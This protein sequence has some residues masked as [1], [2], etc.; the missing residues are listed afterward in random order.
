[1]TK[2]ALVTGGNKGIGFEIAKNLLINGY[3]V[4]I[5]ARDVTRGNKAVDDLSKYG[6]VALQILDISNVSKINEVAN[7]ISHNYPELALLVNNAGIPGDMQKSAWEFTVKELQETYTTDFLGA[8]E[9]S[10]SLLPTIEKNQGTIFSMTIPIE[11]N[12]FF[13]PFAYLSAKAPLNIMTKTW[14]LEFKEQ[15]KPVEIFALMPGGVTTDLNNHMDA[16]GFKTAEEAGRLVVDLI[17][18]NTDR[19]GKVVN[20]DGTVAE[21]V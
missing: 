18:D 2:T 9:L 10:R 1:M 20:F 6:D 12:N 7:K 17:T 19:S 8:Y 21:Y 13:H 3:N 15:N 5:G 14:G 4:V 16:P 11:P